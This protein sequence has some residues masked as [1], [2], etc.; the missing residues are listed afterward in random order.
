MLLISCTTVTL[1]E[2]EMNLFNL[3]MR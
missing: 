2:V 1:S 3:I